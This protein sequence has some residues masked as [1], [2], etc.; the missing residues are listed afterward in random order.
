MAT[1]TAGPTAAA[2]A[3]GLSVVI[4]GYPGRPGPS[5][6]IVL[7]LLS[8]VAGVIRGGWYPRATA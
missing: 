7:W 5:P 4:R 8:V 3:P 6:E 1:A 2:R